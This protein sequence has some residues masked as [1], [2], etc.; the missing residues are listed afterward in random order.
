MNILGKDM[1]TPHLNTQ[2]KDTN[3]FFPSL[4]PVLPHP[5]PGWNWILLQYC[6]SLTDGR[7]CHSLVSLFCTLSSLAA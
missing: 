7:N 1:H 6:Y 4:T 5:F 3:F 2:M